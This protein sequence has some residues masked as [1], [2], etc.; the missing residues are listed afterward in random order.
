MAQLSLLVLACDCVTLRPCSMQLGA[1]CFFKNRY[2]ASEIESQL[3][4]IEQMHLE[5]PSVR[6]QVS[7]ATGACARAKHDIKAKKGFFWTLQD[8]AIDPWL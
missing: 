4:R 6:S 8:G 2:S 5:L 7:R 3:K 1:I